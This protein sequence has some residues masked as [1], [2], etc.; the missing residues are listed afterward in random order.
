LVAERLAVLL[1]LNGALVLLVSMAAGLALYRTIL[2]RGNHADWHLLHAGGTS[3]GV[4]L[5]ALGATVDLADL[6]DLATRTAAF[7]ILYFAWTSVAAMI[8]RALTGETGFRFAGRAANRITFFLYA[9][10]TVAVFLGFGIWAA[11][12][13]DALDLGTPALP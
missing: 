9:T 1:A 13:L 2:A 4:M 6:S 10:G 11:G 12:L 5:I 7:L 8:L 3:R